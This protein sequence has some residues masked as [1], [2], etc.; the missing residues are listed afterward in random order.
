[1][2]NALFGFSILAVFEL[3]SRRHTTPRRGVDTAYQEIP[4]TIK[5]MLRH[6]LHQRH[7]SLP[8]LYRTSSLCR[9]SSTTSTST[10][11]DKDFPVIDMRPILTPSHPLRA[12]AITNIGVALRTRGF[13]YMSH[14]D[15]LTSDYIESVCVP[16]FF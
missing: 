14:V 8:F 1:M 9:Q 13:F 10:S 3:P 7:F 16:F 11:L 4:T 12:S 2:I 6:L 5:L 15:V